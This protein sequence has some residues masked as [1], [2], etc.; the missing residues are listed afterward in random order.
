MKNDA[1]VTE[2][3]KKVEELTHN[4]KRALA[5][6]HNL[7]KRVDGEK[8]RWIQLVNKNI[9]DKLLPIFDTLEQAAVHIKDNG[10]NIALKQFKNVLESEGLTEIKSLGEIFDPTVHECV[11]TEEG[12]EANKISKVYIKGYKLNGNILRPAKVRVIKKKG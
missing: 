10:L 11:D 9:I 4:W 5:D 8:Q 2:L 6:Y 1:K 12:E 7:Q 3:E